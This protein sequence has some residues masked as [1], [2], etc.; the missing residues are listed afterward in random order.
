[1]SHYTEEDYKKRY[2]EL[3]QK[4][5]ESAKA[6]DDWKMTVRLAIQTYNTTVQTYNLQDRFELLDDTLV[7]TLDA[8]TELIKDIHSRIQLAKELV[9]NRVQIKLGLKEPDTTETSDI[10]QQVTEIVTVEQDRLCINDEPTNFADD[11]LS[12]DGWGDFP[13]QGNPLDE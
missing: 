13:V 12:L 7:D 1:M 10:P 4:E 8:N 6:Y 3:K 9:E 11:G 5:Q 2:A